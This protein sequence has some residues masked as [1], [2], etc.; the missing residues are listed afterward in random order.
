M[1]PKSLQFEP[2]LNFLKSP[3]PRTELMV[4]FSKNAK[5]QTELWFDSLKFGFELWF[6][7]ELQQPYCEANRWGLQTSVVLWTDLHYGKL[8][9]ISDIRIIFRTHPLF[10]LCI[11]FIFPL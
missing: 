7:T 8:P 4:Q 9:Q 10:D 3:E 1:Q 2:G 11:F 6:W 5:S